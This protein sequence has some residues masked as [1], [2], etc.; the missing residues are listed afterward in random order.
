M[1][2]F[3]ILSLCIWIGIGSARADTPSGCQLVGTP[4]VLA[5]PVDLSAG[6]LPAT[7]YLDDVLECNSTRLGR[8]DRTV[9]NW[10]NA[11]QGSYSAALES[12]RT[13]VLVVPFQ[14]QG[15]A[16][17]RIERALMSIDLS[18]EI[19][20]HAS[21]AD[22]TLV[23]RA[24]GEGS[25]RID[26][27]AILELARRMNVRKVIVP[28]VGHD[29][30]HAMTLTIQVLDLSSG[31]AVA[32]VA[33]TYQ[34]DWRAVLF[35]D[36]SPP[37]AKFHGMLPQV[38][39]DLLLDTPKR[40]RGVVAKSSSPAGTLPA[41]PIEMVTAA[42][43]PASV[44]MSILGILESPNADLARER[45]FERAFVD[46]V[47]FDAHSPDALFLQV[48]ALTNLEHRPAALAML[49]NSSTPESKALRAL[50][51]GNL[52]EARGALQHVADPLKTML[53]TISVDDLRQTYND[54]TRPDE[55]T[56]SALFGAR[57]NEWQSLV[58]SR[59][60]DL[61]PW[62]VD[63]PEKI[64]LLLDRW[65]PTPGLD[66][67][68]IEENDTLLGTGQGELPDVAVDIAIARHIHRLVAQIKPVIC[69]T[70]EQP[71]ASQW[72]LLWLLEGRSEARIAKEMYRMT[73]LQGN[74]KEALSVLDH[75]EPLFG[76]HPWLEAIRALTASDLA[77]VDPDDLRPGRL[78]EIRR[79]GL[80][81]AF[82]EGG[83]N[84]VAFHG[85]GALTNASANV[86]TLFWHAFG[87]DFPR[88]SFW[89]LLWVLKGTDFDKGVYEASARD[90]LLYSETN[91]DS[92]ANVPQITDEQKEELANNL[93][94]RFIGAPGRSGILALLQHKV[95][96]PVDEIGELRREISEE[97]NTWLNYYNLGRLLIRRDD[98]Y[99]AAA[100]T[101]MSF[102]G[103]HG[104]DPS[105]PVALSNE[106]YD[107]GA[108][109][110]LHGHTELSKSLFQIAVDLDTGSEASI[111]AASRLQLMAGNLESAMAGTLARAM[112]Y[113]SAYAYRDFLSFLHATGH[114]KQAWQGFFQL[115]TTFD[116]PQV[117]VSAVV[118]HQKDGRS[119]AYVRQ[120]L[121]R[122]EIRDARLH[123]QL[124][125]PEFAILWNSTDRMPPLDL[126]NLVEGLQ[127]APTARIAANGKSLESEP[128]AET[129]LRTEGPSRFRF[130][131]APK[132]PPGTPVKSDLTYFAA[133]YT[134]LRHEHWAKALDAFVAMAD[135]YEVG[136]GKDS[137]ALPY[138]AMAAAK[139]GDSIGLE[140]SLATFSI[141]EPGFDSLLAQAIFAGIRK[142][143]DTA[144][145]RLRA[146]FN[147][148][149]NT[150]Y[151][152]ILSEYEYAET[153]EWLYRQTQ[154]HQFIDRLLQWI[155]SYELVQPAQA[156]AYGMEY[157]HREP[158]DARRRALALTLY[159][160]PL[161]ERIK[162][163]SDAEIK[164]A[165]VWLTENN[166]FVKQGPSKSDAT[167][168]RT[169]AAIGNWSIR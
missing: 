10:L 98:D 77:H 76:G 65:F 15:Y 113:P 153:C 97:P 162:S 67:R 109:L 17:D 157:T 144:L 29:G 1:K 2:L 71:G 45:L 62:T 114:G 92:I 126:A 96:T 47:R 69:C 143:T 25:R 42:K 100:H 117:W 9:S 53:L 40:S 39:A 13:Q 49:G 133:A 132:L 141:A 85:L 137:F 60:S 158:G 138:F 95:G 34:R 103:F 123:S 99:E 78:A 26:S 122:P 28:F 94:S 68:T 154:D 88:R 134:E 149:P 48:F 23:A 108:L 115:A 38:V 75:Y 83:E 119:E 150:D 52:P 73:A 46:S 84:D 131:V 140:K 164:A 160:N 59:L 27:A 32:S 139:A 152:P 11:E 64:K 12:T 124:F 81:V 51:N 165:Q 106:A 127:G 33:K 101:F 82:A 120:W 58:H 121:Q 86:A 136:V 18:Y 19:G 142:D 166:P 30:K 61:D 156:W 36:E 161:S 130:A 80:I 146:A 43:I 31:N 16:L 111:T 125:A 107:A 63:A 135:R 57:S 4:N 102:P 54:S 35:T 55:R 24:L 112:R 167:P 21:V 70:T 5:R 56:V 7:D 6:K 116:I 90:S 44:S 87:Y 169:A 72:D 22:P 168:A 104:K 20:L 8:L 50:L 3:A 66:L 118:G 74:S 148:R 129:M 163:A 151:R 147:E 105:D 91:L 89:P 41:G 159:L 128:D 145:T 110:Y 155:E 14:V 79:S 93:Q 37:F